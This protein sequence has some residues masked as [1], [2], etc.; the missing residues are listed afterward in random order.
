MYR[1]EQRS[2]AHTAQQLT[3]RILLIITLFTNSKYYQN[4]RQLSVTVH[5][6][7]IT[8]H[9]ALRNAASLVLVTLKY[10]LHNIQGETTKQLHFH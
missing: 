3:D 7:F 2:A 6:S 8:V 10:L 1:V 9:R 4:K 5:T